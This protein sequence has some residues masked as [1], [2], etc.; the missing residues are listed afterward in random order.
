MVEEQ[1]LLTKG[2]NDLIKL[3]LLRN[4]LITLN[5]SLQ[6]MVQHSMVRFSCELCDYSALNRQCLRNHIKVQHSDIKPFSCQVRLRN[7]LTNW[8]V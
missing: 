1:T 4:C 8:N 5:S 7:E 6:H 3:N 2:K